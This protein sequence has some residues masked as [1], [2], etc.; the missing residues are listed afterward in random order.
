MYREILA[1]SRAVNP[2]QQ[3]KHVNKVVYKSA[4]TVKKKCYH[5]QN[6]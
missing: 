4:I 3:C 6:L 2:K 5:W 1:D